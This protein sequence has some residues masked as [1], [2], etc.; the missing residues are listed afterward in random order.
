MAD[1]LE[2]VYSGMLLAY[3]VAMTADAANSEGIARDAALRSLAILDKDEDMKFAIKTFEESGGKEVVR[4]FTKAMEGAGLCKMFQLI[5]GAGE[6]LP[7]K[8]N[9]FLKYTAERVQEMAEGGGDNDK[10]DDK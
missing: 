1:G 8:Y 6:P 9:Y 7:S 10:K 3:Q 5:L 2:E 4:G